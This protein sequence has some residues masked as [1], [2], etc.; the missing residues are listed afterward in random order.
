MFSKGKKAVILLVEDDPGD[1]ELTRRALLEGTVPHDLRVVE[2][3]EEAL[4]YLLHRS[5]Y[6]DARN[7]PLPDLIL[8][9]L[10]LPKLNGRQVLERVRS[11]PRLARIPVIVLTTS[12]QER[13]M[14]QSYD[15]GACS[16]IV[17]PSGIDEFIKVVRT[18]EEYWLEIVRLPSSE[19]PGCPAL[20]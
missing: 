19:E 18:I 5:V 14:L 20:V 17:K 1:Q 10:N 8:L 16:Y 4:D 2:D 15:S 12:Q 3:G 13:D 9:D 6:A 7:N 11:E